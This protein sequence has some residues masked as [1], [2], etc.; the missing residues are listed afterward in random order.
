MILAL[1]LTM[2]Q[3]KVA[4]QVQVK[5]RKRDHSECLRVFTCYHSVTEVPSISLECVYIC[6]Y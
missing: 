3:G 2:L 5:Y 1:M 6:H 4:V